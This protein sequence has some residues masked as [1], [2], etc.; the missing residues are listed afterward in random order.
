MNPLLQLKELGQS[1]WLDYI[2]RDL[3]TDGGLQRLIDE[4]GIAGVTSNPAIFAKA[5]T[6]HDDYDEA[7]RALRARGDKVEAL[8]ETLALDDIRAAADLL[9][10]VYRDSR[11]RD[12]YVS[13]EV[14]PELADD[15]AA[16][17][18]EARRL[19]RAIERPNA[20]I[21]VPATRAGLDAIRELT[22]LGININ[23]TLIFSP[24]RYSE[25]ADAWAEGIAE[26]ESA[27]LPIDGVA[28]VA[29]FF[30]SRI[31]TLA[32]EQLAASA[33]QLRGKVAVAAAKTAYQLFRAVYDSVGWQRLREEGCPTQRLL[34]ASTSTKNPDYPDTKYV[35]E[36]IGPDT[37]NTLP[38]KT[39]A[40]YRDHGRPERRV[41]QGLDEARAVLDGLREAGIDFDEL[42]ARLERE[43]VDKF[44]QAYHRLL[45]SLEQAVGQ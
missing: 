36:L 16:T 14:S 3:L 1:P 31:E 19:W 4:D 9:A 26:R 33:P 7:I 13:L 41:D 32:D 38:M 2:Q 24:A 37:I 27:G 17:I 23:A 28:S 20:M 35:D 25:V 34:W 43:G 39:L 18:V 45:Q 42:A 11:R 10:P 29:S 5:V 8:Y 15:S 44:K 21:K 40:A 30:V 22:A 6:E 12:G